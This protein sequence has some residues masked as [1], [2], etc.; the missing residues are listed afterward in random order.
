MVF[1]YRGQTFSCD[2]AAATFVADASLV[3][4]ATELLF[5]SRKGGSSSCDD[6]R[7]VEGRERETSQDLLLLTSLHCG[8]KAGDDC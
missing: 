8:Q 6:P 3:A 1:Q 4:A 7:E 2:A 5:S